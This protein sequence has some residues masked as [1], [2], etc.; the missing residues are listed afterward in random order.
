M[1]RYDH[2]ERD[3]TIWFAQTAAPRVPDYTD[4]LIRLTAGTSQRPRW[5]FPERWLPMSVVTLARRSLAPVPWRTIAVLAVLALLIAAMLAAYIGSRP[6]VPPPFGIADNGLVVYAEG[7]DLLAIDPVTRAVRPVVEGSTDDNYPTFSRDGTR[8]A[9][10]RRSVNGAT[11]LFAVDA[12]GGNEIKLTNPDSIGV[13]GLTWSPDDK[14]LA[15]ING[16]LWIVPADGSGAKALVLPIDAVGYPTWRPRDG[17][18]I[19]VAGSYRLDS[20]K[21]GWF[22]VRPDGSNLRPILKT[23]GTPLNDTPV[24]FTPD[25]SRILTTRDETVK[26]SSPLHHVH[27]MTLGDDGQI[28][29]DRTIGPV[30]LNTTIGYALSPDGTRIVAAVGETP[31]TWRIAVIPVDGSAGVVTT[32]PTFEG[33]EFFVGWSPDATAIIVNDPQKHETLL[34]DPSGGGHR[35]ASWV[36]TGGSSWQRVAK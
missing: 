2:L 11:Q 22:L 33:S 13:F 29:D 5:S 14:Q 35:L 7:G 20:S 32:G 23:D 12:A 4:D 24:L 18:D 17:V 21:D 16:K 34:L 10:E 6:K 15:Y 28:T 1:N 19:A 25:G 27:V 3:L 31:K 26:L 36:D 8:I 9:F 30:V